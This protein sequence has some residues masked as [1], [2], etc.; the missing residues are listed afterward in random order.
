VLVLKP[1]AER[2][3]MMV[4]EVGES[5]YY[6]QG[7]CL[8]VVFV[9]LIRVRLCINNQRTIEKERLYKIFRKASS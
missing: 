6:F 2:I 5:N 3:E 9:G 4:R 8:I 7:V 1:A